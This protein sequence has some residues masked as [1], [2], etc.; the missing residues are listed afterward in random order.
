MP[1]LSLAHFTNTRMHFWALSRLTWE[2]TTT[3]SHHCALAWACEAQRR[4]GSFQRRYLQRSRSNWIKCT[5]FTLKP[6][7]LVNPWAALQDRIPEAATA[8]H[9]WAQPLSLSLLFSGESDYW[10]DSESGKLLTG[11][12]PGLCQRMAAG[13]WQGPSGGWE[14]GASG[15]WEGWGAF[16]P[17]LFLV[18]RE[19]ALDCFKTLTCL[20]KITLCTIAGQFTKC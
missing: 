5:L 7:G 12:L 9:P 19:L 15:T 2:W 18:I 14:G 20:W 16:Q 8:R 17:F 3:F 13:M 11:I 6:L 4:D 1:L 10:L